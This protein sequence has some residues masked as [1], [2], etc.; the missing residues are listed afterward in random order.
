MGGLIKRAHDIAE[1]PWRVVSTIMGPFTNGIRALS[2]PG[3]AMFFPPLFLLACIGLT[4]VF[5]LLVVELAFLDKSTIDEVRATVDLV[6]DFRGSLDM[7][8]LVGDA[9]I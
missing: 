8:S 3:K 9:L 7:S 1:A 5:A 2:R 4:I 6:D